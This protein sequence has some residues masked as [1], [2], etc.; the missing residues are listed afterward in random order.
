MKK[1]LILLNGLPPKNLPDRDHFDLLCAVD[2]AYTYCKASGI[3]PDLIT[4]DF[5]SL[6]TI[7]EHIEIVNTPNQNFTDFEKTLQVLFERDITH[8]SIYG[9]SGNEPDHFL[10]NISVALAWKDKL[11]IEFYDDF[12][13]FYFIPN[14]FSVENIFGKTISLIPFP[15]ALG[16]TTSG[17]EFPLQREDLS[18]G[19]RIGTRNRAILNTVRI[20]FKK[21][22]LLIYI[23]HK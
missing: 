14:S 5:D 3:T 18:F 8:I 13:C 20:D 4:G 23:S 16:I 9:G 11:T 12:G 10:G 15:T 17:L 1:A 2:G 21:G 22:N 6:E 7:P 19:L